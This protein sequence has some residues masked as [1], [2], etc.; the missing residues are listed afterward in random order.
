[1]NV[2]N[3]NSFSGGTNLESDNAFKSRFLASFSGS[4]TGTSQG[5]RNAV[6]GIDG[7]L[8]AL[9]VEPGNSLMLR[10]GTEVIQLEDSSNRIVDS[11]TGGKVDIYVLGT[12]LQEISESF[13]FLNKSPTGNI[14]DDVNDQKKEGILL[15]KTAT[16]LFSLFL[17]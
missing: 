12:K 14:S 8:D 17:L 15:L 7:V 5:Y 10:D 4:N 6:L 16:F 11:G 13:I 1:L 9:V 2:T 3:I